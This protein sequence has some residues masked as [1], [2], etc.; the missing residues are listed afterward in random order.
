VEH[1]GHHVGVVP[2]VHQLVGGVAV[3]RVH[4]GRAG[5]ER[6]E[7]RL[8]VLGRVVEVLGHLVLLADAGGQQGRG[9]AVGA[10]VHLGPRRGRAGVAQRHGTRLPLRQRLEQVREVPAVT[11]RAPTLLLCGGWVRGCA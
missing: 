11:H 2:Q 3:V 6:R 5:L 7:R 8:D 1:D 10:A 9:D 4:D